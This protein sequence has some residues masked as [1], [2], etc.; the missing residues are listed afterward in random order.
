MPAEDF[1]ILQTSTTVMK[2]AFI[3]SLESGI[4]KETNNLTPNAAD[5]GNMKYTIT[6]EGM[7]CEHCIK[8]VTAAM[9]AL[10]AAIVYV[11]LND[12]AVDFNGNENDLRN[13]IEDLGF[14]VISIKAQ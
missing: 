11:K 1:G 5:G 2:E 6:T 3:F 4:I 8:R 7:G 12:I 13:A 9:Q 10:N 14:D